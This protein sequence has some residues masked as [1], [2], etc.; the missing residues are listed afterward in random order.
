MLLEFLIF[1]ILPVF[2][3]ILLIEVILLRRKEGSLHFLVPE[4]LPG[5]ILKPRVLFDLSRP[6][7]AKSVLWLSLNH[8]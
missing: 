4:I 6:I 2:V 8:L 1:L 5:K 7:L 3:D